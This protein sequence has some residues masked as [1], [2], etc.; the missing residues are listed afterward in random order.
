MTGYSVNRSIMVFRSISLLIKTKRSLLLIFFAA[1][2]EQS[3]AQASRVIDSLTRLLSVVQ[4][5]TSKVNLL[6]RLSRTHWQAGRFLPAR[7]TATKALNLAEKINFK[8]GIATAH[9][10]L[11]TLAANDGKYP[12]AFKHHETVLAI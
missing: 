9:T 4:D 7:D 5:D 11:G 6:I 3:F 1:A 12:E 8:K 2:C 10:V